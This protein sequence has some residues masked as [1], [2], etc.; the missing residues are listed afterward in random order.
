MTHVVVKH[1]GMA[2]FLGGALMLLAL[3][4]CG[5]ASD[6]GRPA[7]EGAAVGVGAVSAPAPDRNGDRGRTLTVSID[8]ALADPAAALIGSDIVICAPP[9]VGP[10]PMRLVAAYCARANPRCMALVSSSEAELSIIL[11]S[12][13]PE[14]VLRA[15]RSPSDC[16]ARNP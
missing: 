8:R 4:S 10:R 5:A 7:G 12:L 1:S 9:P 13:D 15:E 14:A 3:C 6:R 16:A 11:P 2:R